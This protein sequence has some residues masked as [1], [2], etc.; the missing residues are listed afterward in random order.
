MSLPAPTEPPSCVI[1]SRPLADE[2]TIP[3]TTGST[4]HIRCAE[5]QARAAARRRT[6]NAGITAAILAG[7]L[8]L[9]G[10]FGIGGWGLG[11]ALVLVVVVHVRINHR[12]WR[13]TVQSARLWW[14]WK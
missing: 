12:W 11:A 10:A 3:T 13:Y 9:T 7:L 6:L 14:R 5:Q 4:V 8:A 2:P 1:C